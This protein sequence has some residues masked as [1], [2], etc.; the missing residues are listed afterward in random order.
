MSKQLK[1]L[2]VVI[3]VLGLWL[4]L[5]NSSAQQRWSRV[6]D[7]RWSPNGRY[8]ATVH[9]NGAIRI[10]DT[11]TNTNTP[12]FEQPG[13]FSLDESV[14]I[15]WSPNSEKIAATT[16]YNGIGI[17]EVSTSILRQKFIPYGSES[18]AWSPNGSK[19]AIL[20][21]AVR[22]TIQ[23]YDATSWQKLGFITTGRGL[24]ISWSSDGQKIAV[25]AGSLVEWFDANTLSLLQRSQ[26]RGTQG[27]VSVAWSPDSSRIASANLDG[28]LRVRNAASGQVEKTLFG[29][30]NGA[31]TVAWHPDGTRLVSSGM[32]GTVK[33][34]DAATGQNL[35]TIQAGAPVWFAA[36]NP[37]GTKLAYSTESGTPQIVSVVPTATPTSTVTPTPTPP[38]TPTP[39]ATIP[40]TSLS[41]LY[42][43]Y[44]S[45]NI[46]PAL[47][48]SFVIQNNGA[49]PVPLNEIRLRYYFTR[50]GTSPLVASCSFIPYYP[51]GEIPQIVPEPQNCGSAVSLTTG[52]ISPAV[53]GADSYVEMRFTS[54]TLA[55]G[56]FTVQYILYL[57]KTDWSDFTQS[58][59]YSFAVL[60]TYPL[61]GSDKITLYRH[62]VRVWGNA[63][64]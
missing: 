59:D 35:E 8:I 1:Y 18:V 47:Q 41:G 21:K 60:G 52:S 57:H 25:G 45:A 29:H 33:I 23:I 61:S 24:S 38:H 43:A 7:A 26:V 32:D 19:I 55:A 14:S 22:E 31:N 54:G 11:L 48:P 36:W 63:P 17:W 6:S 3:M 34:W 44:D 40:P 5:V 53:N 50:E 13:G 28:N 2:I 20:T 46:T 37:D 27:E 39:T 51:S 49:Q 58:N 16:E 30:A 9:Q 4:S 62:T 15:A 12:L 64:N 56:G 10:F 42:A